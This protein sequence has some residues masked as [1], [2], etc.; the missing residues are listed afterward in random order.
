MRLTMTRAVSGF[1]GLA[2]QSA[3]A[4]AA[5]LLGR[6]LWELQITEGTEHGGQ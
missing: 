4:L 2:I 1:C 5:L 3:S 6:F